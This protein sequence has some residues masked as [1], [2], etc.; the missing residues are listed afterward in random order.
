M[1]NFPQMDQEPYSQ[2]NLHKFL[3]F[4]K[5]SDL[6]SDN[7]LKVLFLFA[8]GSFKL[9]IKSLNLW[10]PNPLHHVKMGCFIY[11]YIAWFLW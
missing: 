4:D 8:A 1:L 3:D 10:P 2:R 7:G 11:L 5:F 9:E 6:F